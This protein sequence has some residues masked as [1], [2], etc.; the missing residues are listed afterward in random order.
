VGFEQDLRAYLEELERGSHTPA[1]AHHIDERDLYRHLLDRLRTLEAAGAADRVERLFSEW[2]NKLAGFARYLEKLG[3]QLA[4]M[5][6]A[7]AMEFAYRALDVA[8]DCLDPAV[9][10][11]D[12]LES[13]RAFAGFVSGLALIEGY[14]LE[15]HLVRLHQPHP[16]RLTELGRVFLRL[17]GKD[18]GARFV[19]EVPEASP[20]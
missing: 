7:E 5:K 4:T 8:L 15:N 9:S 19:I 16:E 13:E 18:A 2:P 1:P 12:R 3:R 11:V 17:C 6:P 20:E 10:L 14:A